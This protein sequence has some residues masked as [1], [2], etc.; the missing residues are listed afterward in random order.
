MLG[1]TMVV[2][3]AVN[4]M[5]AGS[6][7]ARAVLLII[8]VI[9]DNSV[10]KLN[11]KLTWK[12]VDTPVAK[13]T[14]IEDYYEDFDAVVREL[15]KLPGAI[16]CCTIPNQMYEVR[17]SYASN[18]GGTHLPYCE[19]HTKLVQSIIGYDG[20][21]HT[22]ENLLINC[23]QLVSDHYKDHWYNTHQD[24]PRGYVGD[25]ISTV[26]MLNESYA[27]GEGT[28][29]YYPHELTDELWIKRDTAERAF[30]AQGKP[31]RAI[32]FSSYL[33]HGISYDTDQFKD[34]IRY[35]QLILTSL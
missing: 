17:K 19:Q 20:L 28:N 14:I 33:I 34:E 30:L 25:R 5:V 22:E 3:Q 32:L 1:S 29:I 15:D 27:D 35:T 6:S 23:N 7:P 18:M 10:F 16:T 24:I 13:V 11:P 8:M 31:N 21:M 12:T 26:V 9:F 4:L 2:R